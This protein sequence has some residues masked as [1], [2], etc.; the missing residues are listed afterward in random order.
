MRFLIRCALGLGLLFLILPL[1]NEGAPR[2]PEPISSLP[3]VSA[4]SR[5]LKDLAGFC[6]QH[7]DVCATAGTALSTLTERAAEIV[8]QQQSAP[9]GASGVP[10]KNPVPKSSIPTQPTQPAKE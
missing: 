7:P 2:P 10:S 4:G 1:D 5:I 9:K 3:N 8:N 6:G